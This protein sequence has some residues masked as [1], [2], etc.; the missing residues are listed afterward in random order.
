MKYIGWSI[1]IP[2]TDIRLDDLR[3]LAKE[4][5]EHLHTLAIDVMNARKKF[6]ELNY[7]TTVQLLMLRKEL[8][9]VKILGTSYVTCPSALT[10]LRSVSSKIS[11]DTVAQVVHGTYVQQSHEGEHTSCN[12]SVQNMSAETLVAAEH[13]STIAPMPSVSKFD[14]SALSEKEK[15]VFV[16]LTE[17]LGFGEK[18]VHMA[19][20][21]CGENVHECLTWCTDNDGVILFSDDEEDTESDEELHRSSDEELEE[22]I[23]LPSTG[24]CNNVDQDMFMLSHCCYKRTKGGRTPK[25]SH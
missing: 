1:T 18:L 15:E 11:A 12:G 20:Q 10:L 2:C 3:V 8:A 14:V 13:A 21:K 6:Y 16:Y 17:H 19:L 22:A 4:M 24:K 25:L 23:S 9:Q 7:F 5:E